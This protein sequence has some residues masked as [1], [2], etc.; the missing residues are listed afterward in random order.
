[1]RSTQTGHHCLPRREAELARDGAADR[2][3]Q[4]AAPLAALVPAGG[5]LEGLKALL[6]DAHAPGPSQSM[7]MV[8]ESARP[9]V[10]TRPSAADAARALLG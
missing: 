3:Q 4:P 1:M 2:H 7:V 5:R 10:P 9:H 6:Q 8:R